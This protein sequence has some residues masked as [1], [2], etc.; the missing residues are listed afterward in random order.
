M[1]SPVAVRGLYMQPVAAEI[2]GVKL[3]AHAGQA[4]KT[5]RIREN[6]QQYIC[7]SSFVWDLYDEA[8]AAEIYGVKLD[9]P[10]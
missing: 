9:C 2:H 3:N 7:T 8:L 10:S 5:P 6:S 1:S 4:K